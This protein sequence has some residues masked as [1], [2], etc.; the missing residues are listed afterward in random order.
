MFETRNRLF[1]PAMASL[2]AIAVAGC[3]PSSDGGQES[4]PA[5]TEVA[6][7]KFN[8]TTGSL[9]YPIDLYFSPTPGVASDGTINL[10]T[11]PWRGAAMQTALNTLDGWSTT[12]SLDTSF[13]LPLDGASIGA[14]NP[15]AR[16]SYAD[17]PKPPTC[18]TH[19]GAPV[20]SPRSS[21]SSR[22]RV[23]ARGRRLTPARSGSARRP[24]RGRRGSPRA[25]R[26]P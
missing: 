25:P 3:H 13:T 9:P 18:R 2:A 11:V 16:R 23:L 10:P 5:A 17:V 15:S 14:S 6:T 7:A 12:A 21:G 20:R 1:W 22:R 8:P 26:R 19:G 24:T 4:P